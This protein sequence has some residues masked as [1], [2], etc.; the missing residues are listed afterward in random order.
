VSEQTYLTVSAL[1]KYI[2]YKFDHDDHLKHVLLKGEISNFKR[3][4]RGHFYLTLKDDQSQ[5]SGIMFA[6]NAGKVKFTPEDGMSVLVEGYI[7]VFEASGQYQIYINKMTEDGL[8][9]LHVAFEQLKKKLS[10]EGLFD[11][12]HKIEIPRFPKAIGV[13]TSPTGAA[14][15]DIIHIVNR[16]YPLTKIIVYPTL[17][18]GEY[19][20]D[21]IVSNIKLANQ[22]KLVDVLIIGRGGGSIEDL[23]AFNEEIVARA[24]YDSVLPIIS[25]VGHETDFTIS[26]FVADLRA[27]TPSGAAELA[28]PS[29]TELMSYIN[30]LNASMTTSMRRLYQDKKRQLS[31]AMSS[32]V[33]ESPKRLIEAKSQRFDYLLD[34]LMLLS[35]KKRL[36]Q[37]KKDLEKTKKALQEYFVNIVK[38]KE[39]QYQMVLK[40]L[41]GASPLNIMQKGY[42]MIQKDQKIIKSVEDLAVGD[43]LNIVMKDGI[44]DTKVVAK[45]KDEKDGRN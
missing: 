13:L 4:S 11:Q 1:T 23:W 8:G 34:K 43:T 15:R 39:Y 30:Q 5:I 35:P 24:I 21:D 42:S 45:R 27:P 16:R 37:S 32:Y 18:Q 36:D 7:G 44:I 22:Q 10:S 14:V 28:V 38:Q 19:A 9:N 29:Q 6:S 3:H 12:G 33:F 25:S 17:V 26:D 40:E 31:T 20:K 41:A 2:K